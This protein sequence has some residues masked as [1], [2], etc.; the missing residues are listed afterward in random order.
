MPRGDKAYRIICL[1]RFLFTMILEPLAV[2]PSTCA[3]Y[4]LIVWVEAQYANRL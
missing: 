2:T 4:M 1:E 3:G